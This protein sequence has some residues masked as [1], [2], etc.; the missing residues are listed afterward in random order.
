M[1]Y[2]QKYLKYKDK[3]IKLKE[4]RGGGGPGPGAGALKPHSEIAIVCHCSNL[5]NKHQ[6]LYFIDAKNKKI[7][8][9]ID[10]NI[11][12]VD[13]ICPN[14]SWEKI[15]NNSLMYIWGIGCPIYM[16]YGNRQMITDI[17][18]NA[19]PKLKVGG[20]L[21]FFIGDT[22]FGDEAILVEF[23]NNMSKYE[24]I[25]YTFKIEPIDKFPYIIFYKSEIVIKGYYVFTK[26]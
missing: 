6:Q 17:L 18:N 15:N 11:M 1:D 20:K 25:G 5:K 12:Y 22:V 26:I 8:R 16:S 23:F 13:P 7:I 2:Y 14:D 9:E 4:L 24:N 21:Y 10:K 3:Y 19:K